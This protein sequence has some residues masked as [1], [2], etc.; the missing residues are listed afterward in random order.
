MIL[1]HYKACVTCVDKDSCLNV[2]WIGHIWSFSATLSPSRGEISKWLFLIKNWLFPIKSPRYIYK[3][4]NSYKKYKFNDILLQYV[5]LQYVT[6]CFLLE[7]KPLQPNIHFLITRSFLKL[8][9]SNSVCRS[10]IAGS[11]FYFYSTKSKN[12]QKVAQNGQKLTHDS[13]SCWFLEF[14]GHF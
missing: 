9:V 11:K 5:Y 6:R 12:G 2:R 4:M 10:T 14:F 7:R 3:L 1:W 13:P 8:L